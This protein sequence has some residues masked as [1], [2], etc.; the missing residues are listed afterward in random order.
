[1]FFH[2]KPP[3]YRR[4]IPRLEVLEDRNC[5]AVRVATIDFSSLTNDPTRNNV[6]TQFNQGQL[7]TDT[8]QGDI[9]QIGQN[10]DFG[11]AILNGNAATTFPPRGTQ[12]ALGTSESVQRFLLQIDPMT[13]IPAV[14]LGQQSP[15]VALPTTNI[16]NLGSNTILRATANRVGGSRINEVPEVL[17]PWVGVAFGGEIQP[18]DLRATAKAVLAPTEPKGREAQE[19]QKPTPMSPL[20]P[21]E[22]PQDV[23]GITFSGF[24]PTVHWTANERA[25]VPAPTPGK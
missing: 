10:P 21:Q 16:G 22:T 6:I 12:A 11:R 4:F 15:F 3:S 25:D 8:G 18:D 9:I 23:I 20:S 14:P 24:I 13:P 7:L 1:M 2:R 17:Q 19:E 5:P